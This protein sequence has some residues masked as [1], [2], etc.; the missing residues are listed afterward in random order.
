META[1]T[2]TVHHLHKFP[3]KDNKDVHR[4]T[5]LKELNM[6][7][8]VF[9]LLLVLKLFLVGC[10]MNQSTDPSGTAVPTKTAYSSDTSAEDCYL[11]GGGTESPLSLF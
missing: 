2:F 9:S 10:G 3:W 8:F 6:R 7:R 11:C 1:S 5:V 4:F